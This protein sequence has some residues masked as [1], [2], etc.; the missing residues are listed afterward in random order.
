MLEQFQS[1]FQSS[2]CCSSVLSCCYLALQ[3]PCLCQIRPIMGNEQHRS[4]SSMT[5][6]SSTPV[7]QELFLQTC[8]DVTAGPIMSW[9]DLHPRKRCSGQ[10]TILIHLTGI[11]RFE[12]AVRT[13]A[14]DP[15]TSCCCKKPIR[16]FVETFHPV[17]RGIDIRHS[18]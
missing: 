6:T 3:H 10:G 9:S 13:H 7:R 16:R 4:N 2:L 1:C 15:K 14:C 11:N 17:S 8:A 5:G 12:L 18:N